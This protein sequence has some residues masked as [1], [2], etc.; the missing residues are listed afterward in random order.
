[1]GAE[2]AGIQVG[3]YIVAVDGKK[4]ATTSDIYRARRQYQE[5]EGLPMT[6]YRDGEFLEVEVVLMPPAD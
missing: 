6:I 4:I 3:D 2:E 5:G 1:M